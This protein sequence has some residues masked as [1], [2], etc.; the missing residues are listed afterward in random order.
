[1]SELAVE[2][3]DLSVRFGDFYAVNRISFSVTRGEIFGFLGA[4]GAGKTTTIRVLCGLLTPTEG[5]VRVAG[6]GLEEGELAI[7]SKVGYMSQKFTLYNDLTVEE[8]LRFTAALRKMDH[9]LYV[10]RRQELFDFIAFDRPLKSMV[11]DLPGG[12]KQQ[13]SLAASLLHDPEIIFLDEPTAGVSPAARQRFWSLIRK[14]AERKK[15]VFVTSHYMDEVEQCDRIALM[16]EGKIIGLDTPDGL[17]QSTFPKTMLEFDPK[18]P[19]SFDEIT[20]L[21]KNPVFDFFEPYGL[22]FHASIASEQQWEKVR[23]AYE[24]KFVIRK[25]KPS[26]EDVFI[27]RVEGK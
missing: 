4:N 23:A 2:V 12:T 18:T 11:R 14:L 16:R 9:E 20:V 13:V 24:E 3:R 1:M 19:L 5:F 25:I 10:K 21:G 27:Q 17:K 6:V 15:T 26:L 8:N 22:R 7:K